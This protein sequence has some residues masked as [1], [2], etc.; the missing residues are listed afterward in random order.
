MYQLVLYMRAL[1]GNAFVLPFPQSH[2]ICPFFLALFKLG[3]PVCSML[4][5]QD[6][7]Y[8][9]WWSACLAYKALSP[10]PQIAK[11]ASLSKTPSALEDRKLALDS[12]HQMALLV[13][14]GF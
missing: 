4:G 10:A 1:G 7:G 11:R 9:Q 5:K 14:S 12:V 2:H 3:F 13:S 8:S 6:L